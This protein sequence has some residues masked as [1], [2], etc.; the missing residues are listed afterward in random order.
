MTTPELY[1]RRSRPGSTWAGTLCLAAGLWAGMALSADADP[2]LSDWRAANDTVG[3]FLRGHIDI[4]RAEAK[5]GAGAVAAKRTTAGDGMA[6]D[7][8]KALALKA[9]A[10]ELFLPAGLSAAERQL[11]AV[12]VSQLLLEVEQAW[13]AAVG[14]HEVLQLQ[15]NAT[16]AALIGQELAI[17]MGVIGNWGADRVLAAQMNAQAQQLKLLGAQSL[18]QQNLLL[19]ESL[20]MTSG[21]EL[22]ESLPA[23][24]GLGARA[25]LRASPSELA[26]QRLARMPDYAASLTTQ[27]QWQA[28]AGQEALAQWAQYTDERI[29]VALQ[30]GDASALVIDPSQILWNHNVK[31]ALHANAAI[32]AL[33]ASTRNTMARAQALVQ[34]S[35]AQALLLAN[36]IVPLAMQAE[37]EAVYQYNGMFISTWNLL[38]QY[39][40]RVEAQIAAVG[41]QMLFLQTDVAFKAYL[42]GAEFRAPNATGASDF[43]A[44]DAGGH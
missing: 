3:K 35:H 18:A 1:T 31:E 38:D 34:T 14:A 39:R 29:A 2:Q 36:E 8:V 9:R 44:N 32:M 7:Q 6:L 11:H 27:K 42:A 25:D 37:E 23:L 43:G 19:L 22:P 10:T 24:R 26:D 33:Q 12:T 21:I 30:S 16:E 20:V 13:F 40:A 5:S 17:R 28:L 15:T 4:L 41:A